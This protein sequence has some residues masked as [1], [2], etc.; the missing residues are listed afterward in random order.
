MIYFADG[1]KVDSMPVCLMKD[2]KDMVLDIEAVVDIQN[3]DGFEIALRAIDNQKILVGYSKKKQKLYLDRNASGRIKSGVYEMQ[4]NP[5]NEGRIKLRIILDTSVIDVFANNAEA[6]FNA[7][8]FPEKISGAIQL[9]AEG[10]TAI[11]EKIQIY[12]F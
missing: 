11:L 1:I 4:L 3:C 8:V 2:T 7:V 9:R 6:M 12:S 5:T 10:G